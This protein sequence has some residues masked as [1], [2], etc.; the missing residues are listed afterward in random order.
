MYDRQLATAAHLLDRG[1]AHAGD[2]PEAVLD[3]RLID[4]MAPLRF[5]LRVIVNYTRTW[6]AR[7]AGLELPAEIDDTLDLAGFRA[8]IAA[9]PRA[10]R[11]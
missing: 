1:A 3:W 7:V 6:P 8:A 2:D 10:D 5:Q 4:D 9:L 11:R